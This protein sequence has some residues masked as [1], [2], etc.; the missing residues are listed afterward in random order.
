MK[1][2]KEK[3]FP[4]KVLSPGIAIG[5]AFFC[6]RSCKEIPEFTVSSR[7]VG[8]EIARYRKALFSSR[9]DL[10]RL[11]EQ[12]V[13]EGS[14]EA[15]SV[16]GTHIQM[17]KD[18]MMTTK[19]EEKVRTRRRNIES[20]FRSVIS[21]YEKAF[22]KRNNSYFQQRLVDVKD[23]SKRILSHLSPEEQEQMR[24]S[25]GSILF[26]REFFPSDVSMIHRGDVVALVSEKGGEHSHLAMIARSEGFPYVCSLPAD[27]LALCHGKAVIVDGQEG[28]LIVDPLPSTLQSYLQKREK[29]EYSAET[30]RDL[31]LAFST[32]DGRKIEF[33]LNAGFA[34]ETKQI[35]HVEGIGLFRS[36]LSFLDREEFPS[37][38]E[39]QTALFSQIVKESQGKPVVI[40]LFDFGG[41]KLPPFYCR[42]FKNESFSHLPRGVD[43]LFRHPNELFIHLR[44]LLRAHEYGDLRLLIPFVSRKKQVEQV[45]SLLEKAKKSLE[46]EGLS[47]STPPLGVM[48]ELPAAV[49]ILDQLAEVASFFSVGTNDL[50]QY[51]YGC[52]RTRGESF[53]DSALLKL[54]EM[55]AYTAAEKGRPVTVCGEIASDP[56]ILPL[57]LN[58][59]FTRFSV[60]RDKLV[61]IANTFS[62]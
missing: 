19:I 54:L 17:L 35:T 30:S 14:N 57:L 34:F 53:V 10:E 7:A 60:S 8:W 49:M 51:T 26:S 1:R 38:E 62:C 23:V 42:E 3:V 4:I 21:E 45:R 11:Q 20:V 56:E 13:L 40:R 12:C 18:P 47:V 52:D 46:S 29:Q 27:I 41:D 6:D 32:K 61:E 33:Y 2:S 58:L 36:E 15:A 55:I 5:H 44:A 43:Y 24:F 22:T 16:L 59:G 9:Q 48:I 39:E 28:K 50:H 25:K 37:S 31:D